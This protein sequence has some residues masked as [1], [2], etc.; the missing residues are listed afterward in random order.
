MN[1]S[2]VVLT[3]NQQSLTMRCLRSLE[4]FINDD[5]CEL[6]LVDNGST[7]DTVK[8]VRESFPRVKIL[9]MHANLGVAGGRNAGLAICQG[10]YLM[11]LDNDTIASQDAIIGLADYMRCHSDVGLIAPQ[12]VSPSGE[13]Q[14]S[15]KRYPGIIEKIRNFIG[16]KTHSLSKSIPTE[17][18][19]PFYVIGAAQMFHR[20]TFNLAGP[21]DDKIFFGPEDADF[22]IS[23]RSLGKK[24][25]YY[26]SIRIVHDW[27]RSSS[28]RPFSRQSRRHAIG[29][30]HFYL[31]HK[32][33]L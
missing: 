7:D 27:Q 8:L 29:L 9:E 1:I 26:P 20:D 25:L 13:V 4:S 5:D 23:V 18:F 28:K 33:F 30:F 16:G 6:I 31:K 32:R 15:Y 10:E 3:Y 21:L 22:C 14:R 24:I 2:V 12:L 17:P 11:I 19:E